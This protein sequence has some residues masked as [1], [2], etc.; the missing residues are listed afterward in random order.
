MSFASVYPLYVDKVE[1]KGRTVKELD[2]VISGLT[3][4]DAAELLQVIDTSGTQG[5]TDDELASASRLVASSWERAST[6]LDGLTS[7][8][9]TALGARQAFEPEKGSLAA[10]A[11]T[12]EA[13][14][15]IAPK[16]LQSRQFQ[17][18]LSGDRGHVEPVVNALKLGTLR[19]PVLKRVE[20]D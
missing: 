6:S 4:Y 5:F 15:A 3:G 8:W 12:P 19:T 16:M 1:R 20:A 18:V 7:A 2:Q 10:L 9:T 11:V 14:R 17:L 13:V